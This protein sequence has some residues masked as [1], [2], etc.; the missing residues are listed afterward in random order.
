MGEIYIP[1]YILKVS[2][3]SLPYFRKLL[4]LVL[5]FPGEEGGSPPPSPPQGFQKHFKRNY[6][7]NFFVQ[8]VNALTSSLCLVIS[9]GYLEVIQTSEKYL[10]HMSMA[11]PKNFPSFY[12][13]KFLPLFQYCSFC[14]YNLR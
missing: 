9:L 5:F 3:Y 7:E 6:A 1:V 2:L 13:E 11:T 10:F 14:V 8:K 12:L 4:P